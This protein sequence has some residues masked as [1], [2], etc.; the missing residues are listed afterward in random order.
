[1]PQRLKVRYKE[2]EESKF[3]HDKLFTF[4]SPIS[5]NAAVIGEDAEGSI[6]KTHGTEDEILSVAALEKVCVMCFI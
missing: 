4:L 6:P 3:K 1:M 5:L 2:T